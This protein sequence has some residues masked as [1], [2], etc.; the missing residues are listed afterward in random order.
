MISKHLDFICN[1]VQLLDYLMT[2]III[3]IFTRNNVENFVAGNLNGDEV[4]I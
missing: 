2:D 3:N 4:H 1:A